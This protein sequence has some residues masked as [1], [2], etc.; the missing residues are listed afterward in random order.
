MIAKI[1]VIVFAPSHGIKGKTI[2]IGWTDIDP[3]GEGPDPGL[4]SPEL[5]ASGRV[6][7]RRLGRRP[8]GR[9]PI[10]GVNIGTEE[11]IGMPGKVRTRAVEAY[12]NRRI[13]G[14]R[15]QPG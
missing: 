11:T 7:R 10:T 4:K 1:D 6:W 12:R 2:W 5:R 14:D 8:G 13:L 9:A 15:F 3:N